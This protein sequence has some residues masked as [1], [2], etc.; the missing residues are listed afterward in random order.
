LSDN[1]KAAA[2]NARAVEKTPEGAVMRKNEQTG[3][4]PVIMESHC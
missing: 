2:E 1:R 3:T 4:E